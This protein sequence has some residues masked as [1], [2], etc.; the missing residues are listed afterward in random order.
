MD[1]WECKVCGYIYEPNEGDPTSGIDP[2]TDFEDLPEDWTCPECGADKE[3]F[4]LI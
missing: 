2:E 4:E 1:R 3:M